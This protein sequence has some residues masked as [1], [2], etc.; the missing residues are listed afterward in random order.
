[1]NSDANPGVLLGDALSA[2]LRQWTAS[3]KNGDRSGRILS[4]RVGACVTDMVDECRQ[5]GTIA[6]RVG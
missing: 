2:S 5:C 4:G 3:G 6:C 1:M